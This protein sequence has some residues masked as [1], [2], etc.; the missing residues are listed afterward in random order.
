M[1]WTALLGVTLLVLA[2]CNS[3]SSSRAAGGITGSTTVAEESHTVEL[4]ERGRGNNGSGNPGKGGDKGRHRGRPDARVE[5]VVTAK[6]GNCYVFTMTVAATKVK[7]NGATK[8][9]PNCAAVVVGATVKVEGQPLG[10]GQILARKIEVTAGP[11]VPPAPPNG[12]APAAGVQVQL[13]GPVTLNVVTNLAGEFE[14]KNV[15]AGTYTLNAI[16]AGPTICPLQAGI[17]IGQG[18]NEVEG[19]LFTSVV[20][21]VACAN[22]AL[23][24]LEVEQGPFPV[25]PATVELVS[26][27]TVLQAATNGSGDFEFRNVPPGVYS[28]NLTA[29]F[30]CPLAAGISIVAQQNRVKGRLVTNVV[31]PALP[32]NCPADVILQKLEVKQGS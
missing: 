29:P 24:G 19:R 11:A 21:P 4:D 5:G 27:S 1:S 3:G 2:G 15:P 6:S 28:L 20:P 31:P 26:G 17:V 30:A 16:L 13:V 18:A 7:A 10:N 23:V 9:S 8:F 25:F 14:F 12:T 22:L 32:A